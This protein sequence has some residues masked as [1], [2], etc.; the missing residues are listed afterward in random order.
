MTAADQETY[1]NHLILKRNIYKNFPQQLF[2]ASV[3][4]KNFLTTSPDYTE[5]FLVSVHTV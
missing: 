1:K 3:S 2:F 5:H 4:K